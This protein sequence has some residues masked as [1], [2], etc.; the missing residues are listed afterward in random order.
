ME[1]VAVQLKD[2][3]KTSDT[4]DSQ[5][6]LF[7]PKFT[8]LGY[9]IH[10]QK[11]NAQ[12]TKKFAELTRS[13]A[14]SPDEPAHMADSSDCEIIESTDDSSS[15]TDAI[16]DEDITSIFSPFSTNENQ[17]KK[18]ILIEGAPG[19]GKTMLMMEIGRLWA[20]GKI[21]KEKKVL[22]YF[23]IRDPYI[24]KME[25]AEDMFLYICRNKEHAKV[26]AKYFGDNRGQGLVVLL[27][28]L[29]ENPQAMESGTFLYDVLIKQKIFKETCVVITSRPHA[30][31]GLQK[32]VNYR[33]EIIGFTDKRRQEFVQENLKS[34]AEDLKIYLKKHEIIDTLC[35]IPLNMSI[36]VALFKEMVEE[37]EKVKEKIQLENLPTTQTE[38]TKEAIRIT[39]FHNLEKLKV[40]K[41][42][43]KCDLESLPKPYDQ[44]FNHIT[45]LAYNALVEKRL[46][47]TSDE[48]M[49]ACPGAGPEPTNGLI[50]RAI[51]NGLGLLQTAQF[52]TG[53]GGD[54]ESLSNFAHY[55]VQELLAAWY[56]AFC[57]RSYFQRFSLKCNIQNSMQKCRQ[58]FFQQG[59]LEKNFWKGYFINMWSFYIGLTKGEDTAFI[60]FLSDKYSWLCRCMQCKKRATH[61][62][63]VENV[64]AAHCIIS[65]KITENK[66]KTLL[67]YF[68]LQEAPDNNIIKHLDAV[69]TQN[70]LDV[71]KQ[72][73]VSKQDLFLLG[74][75]LSR[76]Y[77]AKQWDL[78]NL[79]QCEIDDEMFRV[80]HEILTR[81]DGRPKPEI[82]ALSLSGNK[83]KLCSDKIAHLAFNQKILHLNLSNN[84][85]EDMVPFERC[86]NILETLNMSN[87]KL[88]NEKSQKLFTALNYFKRLK[89]LKLNHNNISYDQHVIDATGLALC[90]C[91]SL[92]NLEL[93]GNNTEFEDKALLLFQVINEVRNSMSDIH[94]YRLTDKSSA[95]LKIL[96]Y[97]DQID[98]LPDLCLLRN[99]VIQSKVINVSYNGLKADGGYSLGQNLHLLVNLKI[100]NI[101]KNNISDEA[102]E[103]LT[104][105]MLFTPSLREFK[106]EE[107][108]FSTDSIMV[109]EMIQELRI[110]SDKSKF[111]CAP[112]RIKALVFILN[113][114]NKLN[115]RQKI[116][117]SD[118]AS[119]ISLITELNLSHTE[120]ST[121]TLD[122]KLTSQDLEEL[123]AVLTWF[124]Q[125]KVLDVRNNNI[126]DEAKEPV[127]KVMLRIHTFN[128]LLLNGN[129]I[130]DDEL[131]K[132]VFDTIIN[133]RKKQIQSIICNQKSPLHIECQSIIFIMECLSQLENPGCFKSFDNIMTISINSE[134]CGIQFLENLNFL[135]CLKILKIKNITSRSM[136]EC[137]IS[138]L[139]K[140]LSQS[141]KVTTLDLSFCNLENLKVENGPSN[142]FP[143]EIINFSHS[144]ITAKVL[145]KLSLNMLKYTNLNH[146]EIEG[147]CF[148]DNGII[149]FHK[150]LLTCKDN[151]HK[152]TIATLNLANNHLTDNSA[153][154]IIEVVQICKVK[155]LNISNNHLK[156]IFLHFKQYTVTTLE[157]LNI[158]YNDLQTNAVDLGQ[159][160]YLL[161]NLK[162]LNIT[163]NNIPDEVTK[164][165]TTGIL[166]TPSLTEFRHEENLFKTNS[167]MVFEMIHQL[168]I[169]P[170]KSKFTCAPSR[171][172]AL[173]FILNCISDNKQKIQSSD[174]VSA[175]SFIT[176]LNLSHNEPT[177]LD[178]K[179]T[180]QDLKE[181][182]AVLTWFKQLKVLDVRNNNITDEAKEPVTKVM[183]QIC[184]L[185]TYSLKLNGNPIFEDT[186][187]MK[188]FDIIKNAREKQVQSI[189]C[190]ESTS[191]HI[192]CRC[193]IFIMECMNQLQN[194][195]CF[196]SFDKVTTI[197]TKSESDYGIKFLEFLSFIP[198]LRDLK[199][200]NITSM[201]DQGIC[202]LSEYLSQNK[203]L[204]TLDLSFCNLENLEVKK[205]NS[206][207]ISLKTL[208]L[209]H[210][211][212]TDKVLFKLSQNMLMFS[213]L[214][215]LEMEGNCF[216]DNGINN[217]Y[218]I[219]L[220]CENDQCSPTITTFNL[221]SNQLTMCSAIKIIK[222]VQK[223][224]V[225]CLNISEND[226]GSIFPHFECYTITTLEELNISAN[227]YHASK[228]MQFTRN[229]RCLKS[230]RSL[231]KLNISNNNIDDTA[232]DTICCS[233]MEC[234]HLKEVSCSQNP[235]E[236]NIES[237]F[238]FAQSLNAQQNC[239]D[240][241]HLP[242][243]APTFIS[244]LA[245]PQSNQAGMFS[246]ICQVTSI[247][248][249]CNNLN[250][251]QNF[252]CFLQNCTQL[253]VL[254]LET[255]N[256]TNETFKYLATG[257]LFTNKLSLSALKLKGNPCMKN[258]KNELILQMIHTLHSDVHDFECPPAK[259]E[260]FITILEL[261]DSVSNNL[262]VVSKTMSLINTLN[263]SY[264]E[265]STSY[266]Q[267]IKN[268]NQVLLQSCDIAKLCNYFKYFKSLKFIN[269]MGNNIGEDIKDDLAIA[270]LK[271]SN[272]IEIQ[273]EGNPICKIRKCFK[274]FNTIEKL[275][276]CGNSYAFKDHPETLEA[277]VAMLDY[278][279]RLENKTC[280][281]TEKFEHLDVS[282][283]HQHSR[284]RLFGIEK[285][286]NPEGIS[287]GFV[288]HL[289]LFHRLKTLN[290]SHAYLTLDGL[291]KLARFLHNNDT[292]L[293][294]D[295]S[296]NNI[297]AKGALI[298][299]NSLH[300]KIA[301]TKLNL[302]NNGI[303]GK[304]CKEIAKII[305][306]F[307]NINVTV[308]G[309]ELTEESKKILRLK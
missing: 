295:I 130:F 240:F 187:S 241:K 89:V 286:D 188:I 250:I 213:N 179:L 76:S 184:T 238:H 191:S 168:R 230:C 178:Y 115:D 34:N 149:D 306:S 265:L 173:V 210:S 159:L 2:W 100:L 195:N 242:A 287:T 284:K 127:T 41:R 106:C 58:F 271:N 206:N 60:Y 268:T 49:K 74:Y 53:I 107:N 177:T 182:C 257:F 267:R 66:I 128:S 258:P 251:D 56:V 169:N 270:V 120:P 155:H 25:S 160:L 96:S 244:L 203:T 140:Y 255:N 194:P 214:D 63:M 212:V 88:G 246:T 50:E 259:F 79:S 300:T 164:S 136:T 156:S 28:G 133:V 139:S 39:V 80:L 232:I 176:E 68:L 146:L 294:L 11:R 131:S 112:S 72:S 142:N 186:F 78:V 198:L 67:L 83:L 16:I 290:L 59:V 27:D 217:L 296:N 54:T 132:T 189:I 245:H 19:I 113:C 288:C 134:S 20:D 97:C 81:N 22:L 46:T 264:T 124:K 236:Q 1:G 32:F 90:Y 153:A 108:L 215:Q 51:I 272:I 73:L 129:P 275:R 126:T 116:Q 209:N 239:I 166:F 180:S 14:L 308:R 249:S 102:T 218:E 21:L 94:Y 283:F 98:Y 304:K 105:G 62:E 266:N 202:Q 227:N 145:Q 276:R 152:P 3:Y 280:D 183:L 17:Q 69:V 52:F 298:V 260:I 281:I 123:C 37:K 256:I 274:L 93:D 24:N 175:I 204:I 82:K 36:V 64:N 44:V 252:A 235:A 219:L 172:K 261:M 4:S 150:V 200:N 40:P 104:T 86:S 220:S 147:N 269:M 85:I 42:K 293:Q 199:I 154:K 263:L 205:N 228:A 163:K 135:P 307:H 302:N 170:D 43:G 122:Y 15:D 121:V 137:G 201:T 225:K 192:E 8:N 289:E 190:D 35:Y 12:E 23:P 87:N 38:L 243:L 196:K 18:I 84:E 7:T 138:Q 248:L 5:W 165:L 234:S 221:A 303:T 71:S 233:F 118:I 141:R 279:N 151:Q 193:I 61:N 31:T 92:E 277:L 13:R 285:T 185:N 292:L 309:N 226:L 33:V 57:Y 65:K 282:S 207:S 208:K 247:D 144:N 167:I 117:S 77:L 26:C 45:A 109:F 110:N 6:P 223:C 254:N 253:E 301:L 197:D 101:T 222:I 70:M 262:N 211:N 237:A 161:V 111:T 162:K 305:C 229:M 48:I 157:E 119:T 29:D 95:F 103:S 9:I 148:G 224:K 30:T 231:K 10:R 55:S 181:L 291:E 278:V 75:I 91:N 171:I 273:L 125:L 299:L 99:K 158:S 297:Q 114:I 216:G 143:L 174:I 47:F